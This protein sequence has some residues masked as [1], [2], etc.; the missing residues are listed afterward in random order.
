MSHFS[1]LLEIDLIPW[2]SPIINAV[3]G[4][5]GRPASQGLLR[6]TRSGRR[7]SKSHGLERVEAVA[8]VAHHPAG[9]GHVAELLGQLQQPAATTGIL[10]PEVIVVCNGTVVSQPFGWRSV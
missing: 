1:N 8:A 5:G 9:S 7:L 10:R 6:W 3:T 4:D 2:R